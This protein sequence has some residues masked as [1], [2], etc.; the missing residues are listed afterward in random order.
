MYHK[1]ALKMEE[2]S[3]RATEEGSV[4]QVGNA[5]NRCPEQTNIVKLQCRQSD[6]TIIECIDYSPRQKTEKHR[7]TR[8]KA[9]TS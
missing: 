8:G 3:G 6:C 4:F 2:M 1:F 7:D 5:C 9:Q